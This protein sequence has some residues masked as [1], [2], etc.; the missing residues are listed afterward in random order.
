M[1]DR[2]KDA[3]WSQGYN[4][5]W[6]S[7]LESAA[8]L[9]RDGFTIAR[10]PIANDLTSKFV[11]VRGEADIDE[12]YEESTHVTCSEFDVAAILSLMKQSSHD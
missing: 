3:S 1:D 2:Q 4:S 5:G 8:E 11:V 7:A 10:L 9:F 6:N 12:D